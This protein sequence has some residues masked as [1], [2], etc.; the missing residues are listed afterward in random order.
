MRFV[1]GPA[2][3]F[4]LELPSTV[5]D[6]LQLIGATLK[7]GTHYAVLC[8]Q[9]LITK[10][11]R[12]GPY[13]GRRVKPCDVTKSTDTALMWEVRNWSTWRLW[14]LCLYWSRRGQFVDGALGFFML[15]V[16]PGLNFALTSDWRSD[17]QFKWKSYIC[18]FSEAQSWRDR[19]SFESC[20]S[21]SRRP[22]KFGL[23]RYFISQ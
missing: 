7:S 23:E 1:C 20:W 13:T 18:L 22:E 5:P 21:T 3:P 10:G 12:Y 2:I 17:V 19:C 16:A 4:K 6:N 15:T 11:T 8:C 9:S 14:I